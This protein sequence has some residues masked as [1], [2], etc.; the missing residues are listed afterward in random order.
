MSIESANAAIDRMETDETFAAR[1]RD[2]GGPGPAGEVLRSEGFDATPGEMRD[3][4]LDRY[5]E[6]FTE[7]Q[8][9][10]IAGGMTEGEFIGTM[11]VLAATAVVGAAAAAL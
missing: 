9:D 8:L 3:A 4:F 6:R 5:G 11:G 1:L 2:A 7:E 10:E